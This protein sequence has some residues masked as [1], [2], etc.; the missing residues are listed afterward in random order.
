MTPQSD[1]QFDSEPSWYLPRYCN[2]ITPK[3]VTSVGSNSMFR[4]LATID[5]SHRLQSTPQTFSAN[6]S[7][8]G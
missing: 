2:S 5:D 1:H 6:S 3:S 8:M 4:G 7:A